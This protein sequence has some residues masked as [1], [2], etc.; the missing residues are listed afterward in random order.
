MQDAPYF[1]LGN[2]GG[3]HR[4]FSFLNMLGSLRM[5]SNLMNSGSEINPINRCAKLSFRFFGTD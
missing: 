1:L 3:G 4:I 5:C 2:P